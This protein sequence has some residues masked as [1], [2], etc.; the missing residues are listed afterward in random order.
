MAGTGDGL[1]HSRSCQETKNW[2]WKW[3]RAATLSNQSVSIN[4]CLL[5][6]KCSSPLSNSTENWRPSV[7]TCE[8][9]GDTVYSSHNGDLHICWDISHEKW[10][11]FWY[12]LLEV[13]SLLWKDVY[14][15]ITC[16]QIH[17]DRKQKTGFR[18][19]VNYEFRAVINEESV[20][21]G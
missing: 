6:Q 13:T 4:P 11:R 1:S 21:K 9:M 16:N 3:Y 17:R 15:M 18:S 7:H 19:W 8:A 10:M 2:S 14:C 5:P 12:R 20:L